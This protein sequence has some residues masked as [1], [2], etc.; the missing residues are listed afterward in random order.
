MTNFHYFKINKKKKIRYIENFKKKATYIVF[1][2][3]FMSNLE[4]KN[5]KFFINLQKKIILDF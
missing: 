3:G 5:Q 1:L 2:H 4:G